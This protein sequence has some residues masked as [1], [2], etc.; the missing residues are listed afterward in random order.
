MMSEKPNCD[1]L[2]PV[3]R[4]D[5]VVGITC[6]AAELAEHIR[7]TEP[8]YKREEILEQ[9][10]SMVDDA[11]EEAAKASITMNNE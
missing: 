8:L 9:L 7:D 4:V 6:E 5:E 2:R 1:E 10:I 3:D 11:H